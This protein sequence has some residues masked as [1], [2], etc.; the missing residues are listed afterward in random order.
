MEKII[1]NLKFISKN[2][3]NPNLRHELKANI[4]S[5]EEFRA[6]LL[7]DID[8]LMGVLKEIEEELS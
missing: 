8:A 4:K 7:D 3:L 2:I 6:K 1:K 5:L